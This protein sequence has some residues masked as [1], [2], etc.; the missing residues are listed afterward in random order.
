MSKE[1]F[2]TEIRKGISL[3]RASGP[4]VALVH[5]NDADGLTSAAI[6]EAALARAGFSIHRICIERVHPPIVARI[7]DQFPFTIF[8][9]DLGGQAAPVISDANRGRRTTLSWIIITPRNPP[10]PR[11]STSPL[12]SSACPA[13]WISRL[14]PR[15][16][17]SRWNW[18]RPTVIWRTWPCWALSEMSTTEKGG[19]SKRIAMRCRTPSS[20]ARCEWRSTSRERK[21]T[22][23]PDL[24]TRSRWRRWRS[25]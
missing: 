17:S 12:S 19:W 1:D 14:P 5:H 21:S 23:S 10:T 4:E 3:M 11:S 24:G 15:P 16:T 7:H 8:Y 9:V 25:R 22:R 18:T 6:L 2:L 13:I 20:K